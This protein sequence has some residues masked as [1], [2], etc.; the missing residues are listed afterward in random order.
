MKSLLKMAFIY[1][2]CLIP[3]GVKCQADTEKIS[4]IEPTLS[5]TCD[6]ARNFYGGIKKGNAFMGLLDAGLLIHT[7]K[8]WKGGEFSVEFMNTHGYGLSGNL[9]GDLQVISNI[10][11]GNY[12]FLENLMFRQNIANISILVGLQDL[13]A[14]FCASEYG[15][16]FTNS[17]F[18]IHSTFPLNF[19]V[20]IYPKTAL[21]IE[22]LFALNDNFSF[23]VSLFD[24]DAGSLEDDP[25]NFDWSVS[26]EE[27]F[28]TV[29]ELEYKSTSGKLTDIKIGG[30]SH[31]GEFNDM[32]GDSSAIKGDFGLYAI[33]DKQLYEDSSRSIG[34]FGQLAIFPSKANFN[35]AYYGG[36]VTISGI[37]AKRADDCLAL[38]LAC[39]QLFD[40]TY[41]C[42]IECNYNLA[43]IDHV[44][45]QPAFHY[46]IHPGADQGL[47]N[48]FAG[49]LRI[50]ISL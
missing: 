45:L 22:G 6:L 25:H 23:K 38:G 17:S 14:E 40:N 28:L 46:I 3:M 43:L 49:F 13:N 36:G 32:D 12:T 1:V 29:E 8:F 11:N 2:L 37:F 4:L 34:V 44:S 48:A 10:E 39:S 30:F 20:P 47:D 5:Y 18:G 42:D 7:D 26:A 33:V 24:G 31:S 21:A 50:N 27:G 35:S 15:G 19:G 9:T 16:A 41:E